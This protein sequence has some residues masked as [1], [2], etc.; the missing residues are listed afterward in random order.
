[1]A[2]I[3]EL[4]GDAREN[5]IAELMKRMQDAAKQQMAAHAGS[6]AEGSAEASAPV[7]AT[8]VATSSP[9]VAQTTTAAATPTAAQ[10]TAAS[11]APTLAGPKPK[12]AVKAQAAEGPTS[13]QMGRREFLTFSW[14]AALGLLTGV[15]G[16]QSYFFLYPL[17]REG[18]FGGTFN[19]GAEA[20]LP[21]TSDPP[22]ANVD[23]KF[24]LVNTEDEGA[25][26]IYMVCTHLG[27]LYKWA[28]ANNRFECPCHGSKF[29]REGHYI[30]GP[31]GRSLDRF[32]VTY[33]E[34]GEVLVHTGKKI[35][36]DSK[37]LSPALEPVTS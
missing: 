22:D 5:R 37:D 25:K 4:T 23:G 20:E 32:D 16:V 17:F 35:V 3:F 6:G 34:A 9:S 19:I 29:T 2:T 27:C 13:A 8:S 36:G 24:W 30:S 21:P 18:E 12:V 14:G 31:A 33:S 11:A 26:A 28:P 7:A 10:S 1:M 15:A